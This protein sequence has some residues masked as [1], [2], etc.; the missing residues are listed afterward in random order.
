MSQRGRTGLGGGHGD[1]ASAKTMI[2][3]VL[4]ACV[5]HADRTALTDAEP[6]TT[7]YVSLAESVA[8]AA[9]GLTR[10]GLQPGDP[11]GVLA[12]V[13]R[14]CA[15]AICAVMAAGG[16]VVP[17]AAECRDEDTAARLTRLDVRM[18]LATRAHTAAALALAERSRVRQL[19][20][21]GD[22]S[23]TT[24]FESLCT[25]PGVASPAP[26]V[27]GDDALC[28]APRG[29]EVTLTHGELMNEIELLG[30]ATP[31]AASSVVLLG[32]PLGDGSTVTELLGLALGRGA[33]VVA[34]V[35]CDLDGCRRMIDRHRVTVACLPAGMAMDLVKSQR[36]PD[37]RIASLDTILGAASSYIPIRQR[38]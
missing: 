4:E 38:R 27:A 1:G 2:D 20:V 21:F 19:I 13:G 24:S 37:A 31:I 23:G 25:G 9:G 32:C 5:R 8:R 6:P 15:L 3:T 30:R 18:L 14:E 22:V 28:I 17:L 29:T 10:H 33:T 35:V 12:D 11:V 34:D 16:A 36:D 26:P 7:S